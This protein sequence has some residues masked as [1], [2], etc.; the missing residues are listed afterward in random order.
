[1]DS[2]TSVILLMGI[3]L[4]TTRLEMVIIIVRIGPVTDTMIGLILMMGIFGAMRVETA[5][6]VDGLSFML[7]REHFAMRCSFVLC[8]EPG[9]G[10]LKSSSIRVEDLVLQDPVPLDHSLQSRE[11]SK[12]IMEL[13]E[14][15][16]PHLGALSSP[17]V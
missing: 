2:M 1:M 10:W 7:L 11:V 4:N 16:L 12:G 5:G 17:C 6:T 13:A 3:I 9:E 15:G 8:M 14:A